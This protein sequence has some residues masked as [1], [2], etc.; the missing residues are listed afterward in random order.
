[1]YLLT[2]KVFL[3]RKGCHTMFMRLLTVGSFCAPFSGAFVLSKR[4]GG[5]YGKQSGAFGHRGG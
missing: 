4:D 3:M 1:M 2:Q 5:S